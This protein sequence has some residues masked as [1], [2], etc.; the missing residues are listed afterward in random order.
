MKYTPKGY[1]SKF[2]KLSKLL[3]E[4]D[5][6]DKHRIHLVSLDIVFPNNNLKLIPKHAVL[7]LRQI[8]V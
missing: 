5:N 8:Y 1:F 6:I 2:L 7:F 3:F 4:V